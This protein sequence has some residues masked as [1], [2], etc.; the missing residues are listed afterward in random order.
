MATS[1][2]VEP[3]PSVECA[4]QQIA[5]IEVE[6]EGKGDPLEGLGNKQI[7]EIYYKL[8]PEDRQLFRQFKSFHKLHYDLYGHDT[9]SHQLTRGIIKEMLSGIPAQDAEVIAAARAEILAMERL[10][11]LCKPLGLAVPTEL[12]L[13]RRVEAPEYPPPPPPLQFPS[14]QE[15]Q[16]Q[17]QQVQPTPQPST[18]EANIKPDVKPPRRLAT[19]YLG[20]PGLLRMVGVGDEDHIIARV[21]PGTD[22]LQEFDEDDPIDVITLD[23]ETD[24]SDIDDLSE[25]SMTSADAMT[26]EELQG[27]LANVA[28][29]QQKAAEAIDTLAA[30][31]G[32]M[33]TDQVSQ[34]A[35]TLVT[36]IGHV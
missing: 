30:R 24:K 16:Q 33:T 12:Q 5:D 20:R 1:K 29:S 27:L 3:E 2:Q 26:K 11:D 32:K 10:R 18:S 8:S 4:L 23:H 22:P 13:S 28:A 36:E 21:I 17:Q 25:V 15:E 14:Q 9:P 7:A 31:V 6:G 34:A 19:T 35:A